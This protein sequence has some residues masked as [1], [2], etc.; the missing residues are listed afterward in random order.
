VLNNST[1][2]RPKAPF[3]LAYIPPIRYFWT[4][5]NACRHSAISR[6]HVLALRLAG[7]QV[8][9]SAQEG[10]KGDEWAWQ[11]LNTLWHGGECIVW[12]NWPL[13]CLPRL[14]DRDAGRRPAARRFVR[15][16]S[17]DFQ[18]V[19]RHFGRLERMA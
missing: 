3:N 5:C 10:K 11:L 14:R 18:A 7:F 2:S 13:V 15:D 4:P 8:I 9:P 12:S 17:T 19:A 6:R 1:S 16:V